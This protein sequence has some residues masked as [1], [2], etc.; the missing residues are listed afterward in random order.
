MTHRAHFNYSCTK[1]KIVLSNEPG[2]LF[3][4][5]FRSRVKRVQTFFE[6]KNGCKNQR[7]ICISV[8]RLFSRSVRVTLSKVNG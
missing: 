3:F 6:K 2:H 4:A 8:R 5:C 1:L 7:S